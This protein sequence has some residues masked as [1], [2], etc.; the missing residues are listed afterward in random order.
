[1]TAATGEIVER[2]KLGSRPNAS[3]KLL[4]RKSAEQANG[5]VAEGEA[6][7]DAFPVSGGLLANGGAPIAQP[8]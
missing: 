5:T 6:L 2:L 7:E 8:P 4:A 1:M 3:R